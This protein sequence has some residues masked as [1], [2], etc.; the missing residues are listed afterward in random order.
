MDGVCRCCLKD[1]SLKSIL[2]VDRKET[3]TYLEMMKECISF[4]VEENDILPNTIC[5]KC[6]HQLKCSYLF[7]LKCIETKKQ[8]DDNL[9][10]NKDIDL[11]LDENVKEEIDHFD[12]VLSD[13]DVCLDDKDDI[14]IEMKL[15]ES[16]SED[17]GYDNIQYD[18]TSLE[19]ENESCELFKQYLKEDKNVLRIEYEPRSKKK[20]IRIKGA[21]RTCETCGKVF[22]SSRKM[23]EHVKWKHLGI[24]EYFCVLCQKH[25]V[26]E[27]RHKEKHKKQ[28]PYKRK[29]EICGLVF[30]KAP[31][32]LYHIKSHAEVEPYHCECGARFRQRTS[33]MRHRLIHEGKNYICQYCSKAFARPDKLATHIK[34]HTKEKP[35][36]CLLCP[37]KFVTGHCLKIHTLRHSNVRK[38]K[39]DHC[40]MVFKTTSDLNQH[41]NRHTGEKKYKCCVCGKGF[42]RSDHRNIHQA[43]VHSLHKMNALEDAERKS[44]SSV[45][46]EELNEIND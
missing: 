39:C 33:Y 14:K 20:N 2:K 26:S 23:K 5:S 18:N 35:Y 7:R 15:E 46:D 41:R 21:C 36:A 28:A 37:K 12:D 43:N 8:F 10:N 1:G 4:M 6:I 11:N 30:D 27:Q 13:A 19:K 22:P 9:E 16:I 32:Y 40:N 44:Q 31:R 29:C 17:I 34:V 45:R 42:R 3:V 25:Y 38:Y 24:K